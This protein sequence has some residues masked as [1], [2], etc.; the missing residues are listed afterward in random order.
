MICDRCGDDR[1]RESMWLMAYPRAGWP[2]VR[3]ERV[4]AGCREESR[5]SLLN[6]GLF[7]LCC[8][9]LVAAVAGARAGLVYLIQWLIR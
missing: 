3:I 6:R 8:L 5:W 4:C 1:V 7:L 9:A 2:P